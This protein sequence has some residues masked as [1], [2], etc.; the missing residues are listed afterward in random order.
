MQSASEGRGRGEPHTF[1][2]MGP[3]GV[4]RRAALTKMEGSPWPCC[5]LARVAA[6][7]RSPSHHRLGLR[8]AWRRRGGAAGRR[9]PPRCGALGAVLAIGARARRGAERAAA[10]VLVW[11]ER[12]R[13]RARALAR[14]PAVCQDAAREPRL[15]W[16]AMMRPQRNGLSQGAHPLA[17]KACRAGPG[18]IQRW[19]AA[20]GMVRAASA[21][22]RPVGGG[23]RQRAAGSGAENARG[24]T[25][26]WRGVGRRDG[27]G[28]MGAVSQQEGVGPSAAQGTA[29]WAGGLKSRAPVA[30]APAPR[31]LERARG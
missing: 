2:G 10:P 9:R 16:G 17:L 22:R 5:R 26:C 6:A 13:A 14:A 27:A 28:G 15:S 1:G 23:A 3:G 25:M 24:G 11:G 21:L 12:G 8:A 7:V 4:P 29:A 30:E 31:V 20:S 19:G 18:V